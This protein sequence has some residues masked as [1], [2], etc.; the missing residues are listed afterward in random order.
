MNLKDSVIE[1][2]YI[3]GIRDTTKPKDL[4]IRWVVQDSIKCSYS[5]SHFPLQ[6][7]MYYSFEKAI[8]N[9]K[10]S[11]IIKD[12]PKAEFIAILVSHRFINEKKEQLYE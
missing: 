10:R 6:G 3:I 7:T 12:N 9:I 2:Y 1:D 8:K 11:W 4:Q 5:L